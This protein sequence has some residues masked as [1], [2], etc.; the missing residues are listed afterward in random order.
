M[1]TGSLL[2]TR[3]NLGCDLGG[4]RKGR[5][6]VEGAV[7][8]CVS[9][10]VGGQFLL[11][12]AAKQRLVDLLFPLAKFC[13]V[14]VLTYC[15][16]SNHFHLLVRIPSQPNLPDATLLARAE[17][18]YGKDGLLPSLARAEI[19]RSGTLGANTRETLSSRMGDVSAFMKEFKQRFSR[20]FNRHSGRFGTLWAERFS[21]TLIEDST[22]ALQT[23][24]SYID[25][26]PVRAGLVSDPKDYR[27]CGYSAA[28]AGNSTVRQG[29][30]SFLSGR[31][32]NSAAAEY[33]LNLFTTAG[34]PG[35]SEKKA[36]DRETLRA[37][38]ARGGRLSLPEILRLRLRHLTAG[39][40][41]GSREFVNDVFQ[42]HRH[43]FGP[44]RLD[45]ARPIRG[46]PL[47]DLKTLRDLRVRAIG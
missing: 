28:L 15:I 31:S 43:H 17:A 23:V 21:S 39:V 30:M 5:I 8:H 20:W 40:A 24:A 7:Y 42:R 13:G 38:L 11:D 22:S 46:V 47:P 3:L 16:M 37:E 34:A 36:L 12:E 18:F 6:K 19:H 26:N 1:V 29:L 25:L 45:G 35:H 41:I 27:F 14:E 10:T 44:R 9:R 4:M 33:R 32:W 2:L